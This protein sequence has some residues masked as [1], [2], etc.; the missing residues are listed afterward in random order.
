MTTVDGGG[1]TR[2]YPIAK[3]TSIIF[4]FDE[5]LTLFSTDVGANVLNF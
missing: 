5:N 4:G 1:H 3:E 2:L